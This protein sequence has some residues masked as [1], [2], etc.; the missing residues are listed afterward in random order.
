MKKTYSPKGSSAPPDAIPELTSA[1]SKKPTLSTGTGDKGTTGLFCGGRVAKT[2]FQIIATGDCDEL[3]AALGIAKAAAKV[4]IESGT[5]LDLAAN[6]KLNDKQ[7]FQHIVK[8]IGAVQLDLIT[9]MGDISL[10]RYTESGKHF[11]L[12]SARVTWIEEIGALIESVLPKQTGWELAGENSVE[13]ALQLARTICRRAERSALAVP[14]AHRASNAT[15]L[16]LNR[17][18]DL[19]MLLGRYAN[20]F[21]VQPLNNAAAVNISKLLG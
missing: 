14:D 2:D 12:D 9:I 16:Y 8:L 4:E 7:T 20:Y 3:S 17:L 15:L 18:S 1:R 6:T 5:R 13:A 11:S 19:L 21:A 10:N